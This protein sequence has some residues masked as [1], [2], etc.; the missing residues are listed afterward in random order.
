MYETCAGL[1][2]GLLQKYQAATTDVA[3]WEFLRA[4]LL[5]P[6]SLGSIS[7][8]AEYHDLAMKE[9]KTKWV[10]LPLNEIRKLYPQKF[11]EDRILGMQVGVNHPQDPEGAVEE[12][13]LYW[14]FKET[15]DLRKNQKSIGTKLSVKGEMPS[16]KAATTA[17]AEGL[18]AKSANFC[19]KGGTAPITDM[20]P[21]NKGAGKKGRKSAAKPPK[22]GPN[23]RSNNFPVSVLWLLTSSW[24][25]Q[26]QCE[27]QSPWMT[28]ED[29]RADRTR[30]FQNAA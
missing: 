21:G 25:H 30:C 9:D 18:L 11:V 7:I 5:D 3:K 12:M 13:K 22:A 26:Y 15:T 8:E 6:Q 2:P 24:P 27:W 19:G 20:V 23:F 16:N 29:R 1:R 28:G 4:F 10:Q 14:V 17:L